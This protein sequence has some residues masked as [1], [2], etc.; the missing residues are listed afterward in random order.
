MFKKFRITMLIVALAVSAAAQTNQSEEGL[1]LRFTMRNT[2]GTLVEDFSGK[3][4]FGFLYGSAFFK[5][6]SIMVN[7]VDITEG[8]GEITVPHSEDL[9]PARGTVETWVKVTTIDQTTTVLRKNTSK[10]IRTGE[11]LNA[12]LPAYA[13]RLLADGS[14]NA[15]IMND[16][17]T[18]GNQQVFVETPRPVMTPG[19][20]HHI[21][22][23]WDGKLV[24][25]YIDGE[26]LAKKAYKEIPGTGLS[27]FGESSF[28]LA[29]G[30]AFIGQ[31][32]ETRVYNR[33]LS[34]QE[35]A[36]RFSQMVKK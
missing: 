36:T 16:D 20:W 27:Y 13:I 7:S 2:G 5:G 1:Q 35:V 30:N 21:A 31:I 18:K 26:V 32:G 22:L 12:P 33:P 9:Q 17:P 14:V 4:H 8:S 11:S 23:Q 25:L 10:A 28:E 3:S 19:V 24:R 29:P 6:D 34:D 15:F